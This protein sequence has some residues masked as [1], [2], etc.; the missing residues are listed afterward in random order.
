[1]AGN[2]VCSDALRSHCEQPSWLINKSI[3]S[4]FLSR[5]KKVLVCLVFGHACALH[6]TF[7]DRGSKTKRGFQ[8]VFHQR[9]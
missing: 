2:A 1:M 7:C 6:S 5:T 4:L 9:A 3:E 8:G